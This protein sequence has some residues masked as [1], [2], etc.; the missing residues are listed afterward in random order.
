KMA[1]HKCDYLFSYLLLSSDRRDY[2]IAEEAFAMAIE[3]CLEPRRFY[4]V[5]YS[6]VACI[7]AF[8]KALIFKCLELSGRRRLNRLE[9]EVSPVCLNPHPH[10]LGIL[11]ERC[12]VKTKRN[13]IT[14]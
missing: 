14:M 1:S 12:T 3:G 7:K 4:H 8:Q 2:I 11:P 10:L 9:A 6:W 5:G 13:L